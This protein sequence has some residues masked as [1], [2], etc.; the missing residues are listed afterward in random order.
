[1]GTEVNQK[2]LDRMRRLCSM[3]EYCAEDIRKKI[4]AAA[5]D[6][7]AL[8]RQTEA[9]LA[10]LLKDKYVDDLRYASAFARDK[11]SISGWGAAK[12]RYA[13]SIK[14]I[15]PEII[16]A[17]L[18]EIDS[19]KASERLSKLL[20]NKSRAL[21]GDPRRREKLIRFALSRGYSYDDISSILE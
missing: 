17:A 9:I 19:D 21:C 18:A 6:D 16:S 2:V 5:A 13:L 11:S 1:M 4:I 14:K 10:S 3:R 20:E 8:R 7:V 12:I 15:D